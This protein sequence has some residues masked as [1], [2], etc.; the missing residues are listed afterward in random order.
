[1]N[2]KERL[3]GIIEIIKSK[4]KLTNEKLSELLEYNS[5]TYISDILGGSKNISGLFLIRLEKKF[6]ANKSYIEKGEGEKFV[7]FS[8]SKSENEKL[9][10]NIKGESI[11]KEGTD[12]RDK[13]I[14]L[15]EKENEQKNKLIEAS[16]TE[17]QIGQRI[18]QAHL[19]TLLQITV[20]ETATM[21]GKDV[22]KELLKANKVV[23]ENYAAFEKTGTGS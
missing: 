9:S 4:H 11:N 8:T 3:K 23:A 10:V 6:G 2:K 18:S 15:L 13:Y 7:D 1:M 17:L 21:Q 14:A 19:K 20:V 16:L 5:S 12:Y 22:Q